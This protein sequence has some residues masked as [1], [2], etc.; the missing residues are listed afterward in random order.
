MFIELAAH[1]PIAPVA[2][3]SIGGALRMQISVIGLIKKIRVSAETGYEAG[4]P[5][6]VQRQ[7]V[8]AADGG[9]ADAQQQVAI[10][11]IIVVGR[12]GAQ[13]QRGAGRLGGFVLTAGSVEDDVRIVDVHLTD[14]VHQR[15]VHVC[16]NGLI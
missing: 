12:I 3:G 5:V 4:L 9:S 6:A 14:Q 11:G 13:I 15:T 1:A 8:C 16:K 7:I 10:L 2:G